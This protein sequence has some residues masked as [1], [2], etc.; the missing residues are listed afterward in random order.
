M[1]FPMVD[2]IVPTLNRLEML[3][4]AIASIRAQTYENWKLL[5]ADNG[6]TDGTR[7]WLDSEQISWVAEDVKGAGAARNAGAFATSSPLIYFLDSD[8]LAMPNTL[9]LL[10]EAQQAQQVDLCFGA[11]QNLVMVDGVKLHQ[12]ESTRPA[13]ISSTS[14]L[15]REA[16]ERYG[17]FEDDNHSWVAWYLDAKDAGLTEFSLA[18]QVCLRR[19][20][21]ANV[22]S[23]AGAKSVF[24]D[25][26]RSRLAQ[27]KAQNAVD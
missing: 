13:P 19:I 10:V 18:E 6:S 23:E 25:L 12:Q 22:S 24:F 21:G 1:N 7:E 16:F 11:A 3:Q 5:V 2:V 14:I 15:S 27:K 4:E 26:I 17:R 9:A 8:D 20:H